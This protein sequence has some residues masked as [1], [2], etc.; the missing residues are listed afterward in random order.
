MNKRTQSLE[1]SVLSRIYGRGRG[2][3][4]TPKEFLDLGS[5]TA[6]A[7]ALHTLAKKGVIRR[8]ARGLYDYPRTSDL[9]G[10]LPPNPESIARALV[11][12]EGLRLQPA[13]ALA[14]NLLG[15][16]EQV[17]ARAM[18]LTDAPSRTVRVGRQTVILRQ[19]TPRNMK[20]HNRTSGLVVQAFRYL[21][22]KNVGTEQ[23]ATLRE[24]LSFEQRGKI[25]LD[26][27]WAPAWI[28]EVMRTLACEN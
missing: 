24:R 4:F 15:L 6:I 22:R 12:S 2:V 3:A 7:V 17:P 11:G 21:G 9:V 19:T 25:A 14:A 18:Y 27:K 5:Q 10:L 8:L 28:A 1:K 20:L 26:A 16:S 23:I 13:G